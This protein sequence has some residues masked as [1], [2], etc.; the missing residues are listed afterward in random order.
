MALRSIGARLTLWYTGI[1]SITLLFLGSASYGLMSYSLSQDINVALQGVAQVIAGRVRA[2][3]RNPLP[4]D[5][6]D[7]FRR[8][9][10]FSP[11]DRYFDMIDP[12]DRQPTDPPPKPLPLPISPKALQNALRGVAS[13]ET[14]QKPGAYPVRVLVMPLVE[15]GRVVHV[16][17]VGISLENL[18]RTLRRFVLIMASLFPLGLLLAGGGGW[19][20]A[21][22]ALQ[23]MD[24]MTQ[25]ARR[26]SGEHLEERLHETGFG[27]ELDRLAKTL[28]DML[29]RLDDSFRQIRQFSAD[30]SHELQ[31]PLTILRGEIEVALRAP[32]SQKEYEGVL[33]SCLEEIERISRLVGG[34]LLLARADA[35]VLRLDR[36][37]VELGELVTEV[38]D[39]LGRLAAEKGL[40]LHLEIPGEVVVQADREHLERLLVNLV[41]NAIKYTPSGGTVT[42]SLGE[43]EGREA[44][45][46]IRDTGRGMTPEE[47]GQIFTRFYR[48]GL[49]RTDD[50]PGVGLGLCIANSIAEAH[51]GRIEVTS[52]SGQG[53]TF[54]VV[55]PAA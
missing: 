45:I 42:L 2:E 52:T 9:F 39:R 25:D 27:D 8:F 12:K 16:V 11:S 6:D 17:Q 19:L 51:S 1:L 21:R 49:A 37:P 22:R 33:R 31:T 46:S 20:L 35:G 43:A 36:Q 30:A 48:A 15:E 24:R 55:L 44:R 4:P 47:Q 50:G 53:S 34:L 14:I 28:N 13:Y 3:G 40:R 38:S 41:D 32:R 29:A 5:V 7:L 23:P 26:I 18:M 10:G 54:T